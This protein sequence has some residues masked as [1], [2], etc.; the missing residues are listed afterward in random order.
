MSKAKEASYSNRL[1]PTKRGHWHILEVTLNLTS[2][3]IVQIL[4]I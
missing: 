1:G 2:S 4:R 3:S